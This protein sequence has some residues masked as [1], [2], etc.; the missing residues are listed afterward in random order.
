MIRYDTGDIAKI[1][2]IKNE[3]G[4]EEPFLT[5]IEGR[6]MD[7]IYNT[8]GKLVSSHI[9]YNMKKYGNFKQFQF[10]QY[11]KKEYLLK[12]NTNKKILKEK[13]LV[14][15]YKML[16]GN[17]ANIKIVYVDGIPLLASGKKKEVMNTYSNTNQ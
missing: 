10:V 12:L 5:H 4:F 13:E 16:L 1:E 8:E 2:V 11:G 14:N 17:D 15:E 9:S 3:K 6:K 7:L